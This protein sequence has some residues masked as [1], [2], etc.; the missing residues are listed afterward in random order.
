M[1]TA[2][3]SWRGDLQQPPQSRIA[4][5]MTVDQHYRWLW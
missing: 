2:P 4:G 3:F 1:T 5:M